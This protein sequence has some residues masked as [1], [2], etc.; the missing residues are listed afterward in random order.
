[1]P[2]YGLGLTVYPVRRYAWVAVYLTPPNTSLL[3]M[4]CSVNRSFTGVQPN[5]VS[6]LDSTRCNGTQEAGQAVQFEVQEGTEVRCEPT[7]HACAHPNKQTSGSCKRG[8]QDMCDQSG[9][10]LHPRLTLCTRQAERSAACA[11]AICRR[12]ARRQ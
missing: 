9:G 7:A 3:C 2:P 10:Q 8:A 12:Q 11:G 5:A 1:M 4:A 6:T